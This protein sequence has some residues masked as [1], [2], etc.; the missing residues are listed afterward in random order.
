MIAKTLKRLEQIH[1][2][3][4]GT[5]PA[6]LHVEQYA[7]V[8]LYQASRYC[9]VDTCVER[10]EFA[11]IVTKTLRREQRKLS[12]SIH[13]LQSDGALEFVQNHELQDYLESEGITHRVTVRYDHASNGSSKY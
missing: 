8:F 4:I 1:I 3:G 2:D 12:L 6:G 11:S 10:C 13:K 5:L 7:L 9:I